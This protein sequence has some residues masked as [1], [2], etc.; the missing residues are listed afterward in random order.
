MYEL[1]VCGAD[2]MTQF[3][4]YFFC[5]DKRKSNLKQREYISSKPAT[6]TSK[7]HELQLTRDLSKL[8]KQLVCYGVYIKPNCM[9]SCGTTYAVVWIY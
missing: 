9:Y 7:I 6:T 2:L 1:Y 3:L 8:I 4:I 5:T